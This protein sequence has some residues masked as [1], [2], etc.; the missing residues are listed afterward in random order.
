MHKHCSIVCKWHLCLH[1]GPTNSVYMRII[2]TAALQWQYLQMELI[3]WICLVYVVAVVNNI[4]LQH[5]LHCVDLTLGSTFCQLCAMSV[6]I[7]SSS[8]YCQYMFQPNQPSAGVQVVV[9]KESAAH[10]SAVL[11]FLCEQQ[12]LSLQQ[13]KTCSDNKGKMARKY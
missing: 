9:M 10:C 2:V 3:L 6:N 1:K 13:A 7:L 11:L 8:L 4:K 12:S 5:L